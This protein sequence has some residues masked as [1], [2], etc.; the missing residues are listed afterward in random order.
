[1]N[2]AFTPR[3]VSQI[4]QNGTKH[5]TIRLRLLSVRGSRNTVR[6][7]RTVRPIHTCADVAAFMSLAGCMW[8]RAVSAV[9]IRGLPTSGPI[10]MNVAFRHCP[11]W[12]MAPNRRPLG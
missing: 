4:L 9:T 2:T 3:P 8:S 7:R 5:R 10:R 12:Q 6:G 1:M 11:L